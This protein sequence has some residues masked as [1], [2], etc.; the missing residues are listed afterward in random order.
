LIREPVPENATPAV[1]SAL[2]KA[3]QVLDESS[4]KAANLQLSITGPKPDKTTVKIN[5]TVVPA[6]GLGVA[7]PVNP[8]AADVEVSAEGYYS[9][10]EHV[11]LA[12][13]EKLEI[14]VALRPEPQ[15]AE[16]VVVAETKSPAA[17]EPRPAAVS[18]ERPPATVHE[19]SEPS[20]APAYVS[21]IVGAAGLG[22]GAYYGMTA[23]K[24]YDVLAPKCQNNVCPIDEADN[25]ESARNKGTIATIGLGVGAGAIILGTILLVTAGGDDEPEHASASSVN[26]WVGSNEVGVWGTF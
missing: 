5:G 15:K 16:P 6:A 21:F 12:A 24:D 10:T 2:A 11:T 4:G 20:Y 14:S 8:G 19:K 1:L 3:K 17:A 13:G 23:K 25:L 26:P 9:Q 7:F 22:V 18:P